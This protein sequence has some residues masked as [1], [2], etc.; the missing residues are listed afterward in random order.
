M[1][2]D[3]F[4]TP[5]IYSL[6]FQP[7]LIKSLLKHEQEQQNLELKP[8]YL[9]DEIE[10]LI[11]DCS[12]EESKTFWSATNRIKI[13]H[14]VMESMQKIESLFLDLARESTHD[15]DLIAAV[16]ESLLYK[17]TAVIEQTHLKNGHRA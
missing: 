9:L 13:K 1:Q 17:N 7:Q 14:E 10:Q 2:G 12:T 6:N 16:S 8:N 15:P 11:S 5:P 4:P 3:A